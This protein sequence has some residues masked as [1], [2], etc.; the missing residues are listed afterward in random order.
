MKFVHYMLIQNIWEK[1]NGA[2]VSINRCIENEPEYDYDKVRE[3][4]RKVC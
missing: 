3:I 1:I 4:I 2:D